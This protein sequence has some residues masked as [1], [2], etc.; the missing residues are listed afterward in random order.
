MEG[1]RGRGRR[2]R[3]SGGGFIGAHIRY[4]AKG[5]R[6][7]SSLVSG[8]NSNSTRHLFRI[9]IALKIDR[10]F[11]REFLFLFIYFLRERVQSRRRMCGFIGNES[12]A[13]LGYL[14]FGGL[15]D[16]ADSVEYIDTL[17]RLVVNSRM[18]E[19]VIKKIH[20]ILRAWIDF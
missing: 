20:F 14:K 2:G 5:C 9:K 6:R 15:L 8:L 19:N 17:V 1:R 16:S 12:S 7:R 10:S 4:R 11:L 3:G 18:R 13:R